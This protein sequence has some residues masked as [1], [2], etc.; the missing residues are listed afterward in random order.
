MSVRTKL[1]WDFRG[2][3]AKH[4]AEHHA[5]HLKEF[6]QARK[7]NNF[8]CSVEERTPML[9]SA[10]LEVEENESQPVQAALR[11]HRIITLNPK[12]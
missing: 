2:P 11:P 8:S 4:I 9:A 6:A 10:S 5:K 3:D 7:L 1:I 12:E